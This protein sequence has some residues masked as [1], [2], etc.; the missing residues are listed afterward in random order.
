MQSLHKYQTH[1]QWQNKYNY[2]SVEVYSLAHPSI[3]SWI[4]RFWNTTDNQRWWRNRNTFCRIHPSACITMLVHIECK[5]RLMLLLA[6]AGKYVTT[7]YSP[8]SPNLCPCDFEPLCLIIFQIFPE[9]LQAVDQIIWCINRTGSA[10]G[11]LQLPEPGQRVLNNT[12]YYL[13]GL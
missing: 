3:C 12:G 6:R 11:I 8:Y 5:L 9:I 13:E 1:V 2:V 4:I 7:Y 10:S